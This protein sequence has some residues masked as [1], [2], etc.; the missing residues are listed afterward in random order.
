MSDTPRTD[1]AL[2]H[3]GSTFNDVVIRCESLIEVARQMERELNALKADRDEQEFKAWWGDTY[4]H[5]PGPAGLGED[6]YP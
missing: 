2:T 5:E 4:P 6:Y 3:R 1:A